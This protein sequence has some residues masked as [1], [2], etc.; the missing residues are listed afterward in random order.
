METI[1]ANCPKCKTQYQLTEEQLAVAQGQVRC[2]SCMTV[3]QARDNSVNAAETLGDADDK[4]FD[5]GPTEFDD[6]L[7]ALDEDLAD[8]DVGMVSDNIS[9]SFNDIQD[10]GD[11]FGAISDSSDGL[12][13]MEA[14]DASM[15][16]SWAENLLDE[17]DDLNAGLDDSQTANN[18]ASHTTPLGADA[19][20]FDDLGLDEGIKLES[21]DEADDEFGFTDM[22]N[23]FAADE[24]EGL[25]QRITP[26][27]LEFQLAVRGRG[28][29]KL[30]YGIVAV[31]AVV[32]MFIQYAYFEFDDLARQSSWRPVY[33]VTCRVLGC[34]LPSL[35]KVDE[36]SAKHLTVKSHPY[37]QGVLLVDTIITNH[38]NIQQ[39]FPD[40]E[41]YFTDQKQEI[42]AARRIQPQEYLRGELAAKTMMPSRQPIHL[43][44]EINDPGKAASG[45]W[46]KP[47]Y[48]DAIK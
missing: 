29:V 1:T 22:S 21:P 5:D 32:G 35:Y 40:L 18:Q 41:L 39:P 44:I 12:V 31:V 33:S 25:L 27:P 9:D 8:F 19:N 13:Q 3:F 2:G 38:A 45:Y 47:V 11:S 14:G 48:T 37:Y 15:D 6:G 28:L 4:L 16:E 23:P 36:I 10:E 46:M 30:F 17:D 26:E 43:A 20:D 34:Q 7:A 42:V 24:K